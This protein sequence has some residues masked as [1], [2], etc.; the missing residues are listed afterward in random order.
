MQQGLADSRSRR[1]GGRQALLH[2]ASPDLLFLHNTFLALLKSATSALASSYSNISSRRNN[3]LFAHFYHKEWEK[4]GIYEL[5]AKRVL[6]L[7]DEAPVANFSPLEMAFSVSLAMRS[8][9]NSLS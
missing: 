2:P 7:L 5:V 1:R 3:L 6:P 4:D 9:P 8:V